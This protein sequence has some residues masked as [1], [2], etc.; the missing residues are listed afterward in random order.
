MRETFVRSV[1]RVLKQTADTGT[2]LGVENH[3]P[4]AND[5]RWLDDVLTAVD[6]PR[7]GLTLDTGNFYWYG[8]PLSQMY[9]LIEHF[10]PRIKHT[11]LKNVNY[12]KEL[13]DVRRE[14]GRGYKE[15]CC[16]LDEGNLDLRRVVHILRTAGGYARDLC[17]EDESL[18]KYNADDKVNVLRRDVAAVRAAM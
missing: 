16:P 6:D 14:I 4:V 2:D 9:G 8:F 7:L 1:A 11:H 17:V 12:P 13:A 5:P 10:A 3:G 15:A 18:F